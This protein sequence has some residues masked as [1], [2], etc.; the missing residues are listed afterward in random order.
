MTIY[1]TDFQIRGF[2]KN[3]FLIISFVERG[4]KKK[5][6]KQI[7]IGM[8]LYEVKKTIEICVEHLS[9]LVIKR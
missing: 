3:G 8:S 2:D 6:Y 9:N 7:A 5:I 4:K 1:T